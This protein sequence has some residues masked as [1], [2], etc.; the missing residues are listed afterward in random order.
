M[1][2]GSPWKLGT[3]RASPADGNRS[4]GRACPHGA[5]QRERGAAC[6]HFPDTHP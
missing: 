2:E 6:A 5:G 3:C 1:A 4:C